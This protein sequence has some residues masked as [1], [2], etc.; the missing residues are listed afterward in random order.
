MR[1]YAVIA[2]VVVAAVIEV[3]LVFVIVEGLA[4]DEDGVVEV[5]AA[6][7]G[8]AVALV[9]VDVT[10]VVALGADGAVALAVVVGR[11]NSDTE[12][13]CVNLWVL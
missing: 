5:G 3:V 11:S 4:G 10:V 2:V 13:S 7:G 1:H 12:G 6:V 9:G 8:D